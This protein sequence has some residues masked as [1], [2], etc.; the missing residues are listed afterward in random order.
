MPTG[1]EDPMLPGVPDGT[2]GSKP[3]TNFRV[4][5][6]IQTRPK[7]IP[8]IQEGARGRQ[9]APFENRRV[10]NRRGARTSEASVRGC[11]G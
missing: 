11:S 6:D 8:L 1:P 10:E 9:P 2:P 7:T 3:E 5:A 4:G